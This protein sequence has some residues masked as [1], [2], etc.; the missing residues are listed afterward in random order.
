MLTGDDYADRDLLYTATA[1]VVLN[2]CCCC[3]DFRVSRADVTNGYVRCTR[4]WSENTGATDQAERDP[5]RRNVSY[6][7]SRIVP[8][9][10]TK[11]QRGGAATWAGR[12]EV[13]SSRVHCLASQ[14]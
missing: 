12:P 14:G 5:G 8:N 3:S 1:D 9:S 13:G 6:T 10:R 2:D 7:V 11:R 4:N